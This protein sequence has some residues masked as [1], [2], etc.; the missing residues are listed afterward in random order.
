MPKA[1]QS[2]VYLRRL[3]A[4]ERLKQL[5][6]EREALLLEFPELQTVR[7]R[8]PSSEAI[9]FYR[10]RWRRQPIYGARD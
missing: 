3:K 8:A 1:L 2:A 4:R 10:L 9:R 5:G 6:Q 7:R